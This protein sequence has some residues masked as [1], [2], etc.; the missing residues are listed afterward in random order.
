MA[1]SVNLWKRW[2]QINLAAAA[3]GFGRWGHG[4]SILGLLCSVPPMQ[5][6][7]FI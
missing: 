4:S 1:G 5:H 7:I 6:D 2:Y 3:V